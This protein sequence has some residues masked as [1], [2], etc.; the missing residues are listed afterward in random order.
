MPAAVLEERA[1]VPS[2]ATCSAVVLTTSWATVFCRA[3]IS[4][5]LLHLALQAVIHS[6]PPEI[7]LTSISVTVSSF[8]ASPGWKT[9]F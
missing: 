7:Q 6:N 3:I 9:M 4:T 1:V 2:P 5:L 8:V